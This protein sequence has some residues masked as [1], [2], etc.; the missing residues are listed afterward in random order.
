MKYLKY[1]KEVV[2]YEEEEEEDFYDEF[3]YKDLYNFLVEHGALDNY[4]EYTLRFHADLQSFMLKYN[5]S[6]L[7]DEAFEWAS[8]PLGYKF[9]SN[10]HNKWFDYCMGDSDKNYLKESIDY[11]EEEE[12]DD[13]IDTE[14]VVYKTIK[15]IIN[16]K[17]IIDVIDLNKTFKDM[18][19]DELD[20]VEI[21]M[22][23]E[24]KLNIA[25]PD[26]DLSRLSDDHADA[27]MTTDKIKLIDFI[28]LVEKIYYD[29]R[30]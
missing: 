5:K 3:L 12:E 1:L 24:L 28:E 20:F 27:I 14:G 22:D 30:N 29:N 13:I 6:D 25:I 8:N 10:L 19:L 16:N 2:D 7:I 26:D 17:S 18:G 15:N 4:I 21:V 11:E 23:V 9:W